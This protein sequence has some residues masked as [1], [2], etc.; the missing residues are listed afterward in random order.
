MTSSTTALA[1]FGTVLGTAPGGVP[2]YSCDYRTVDE[3]VL[4]D[5]HAF[6]SE[7]DG[8]YM[9]Y[10]WQCVELAR[11]WLYHNCGLIFEDVGMAYEIFDLTTIRHK[12]GR[13][14]PLRAFRNGSRRRPEPGVR[15]HAPGQ[16][17][18]R[19]PQY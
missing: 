7:V 17:V 13:T 10:K 18:L 16:R 14:L 9:G 12:D 6:R 3:A 2:V 5:R 8:V 1:P 11:R 4:P 19:P 15:T